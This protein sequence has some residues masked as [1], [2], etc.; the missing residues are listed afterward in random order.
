MAKYAI[1]STT[2]TGIADAIREKAGTTGGIA[3]SQMAESILA[4]KGGLALDVVTAS[5]LPGTVVDGQIVV[6]STTPANHVYITTDEP[7]TAEVGDI[8]IAIEPGA[9]IRW[10]LTDETSFIRGGLAYAAQ[11]NGTTW[12]I[13]EAYYGVAGAWEQFSTTLPPVGTPLESMPWSDIAKIAKAGKGADYF[14][15]GDKK[16]VPVSG[17]VGSDTISGTRYCKIIGINHNKSIEG[18]GIH[19]QFLWNGSD[20]PMAW[21]YGHGTTGQGYMMNSSNS[22][23]GGWQSSY[24]RNT[25]C[26]TFL[27]RL[28]AEMQAAIK[29]CRK[30]TDNTGNANSSDATKVTETKD[31]IFL[32]SEY[33]VF[34]SAGYGNAGEKDYQAQYEYY[35]AG[36]RKNRYRVRST[37]NLCNWWLRSAHRASTNKYVAV[38]TYGSIMVGEAYYS[39]GFAPC[40]MV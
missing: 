4:I 16:S 18:N 38:D 26:A 6:E 39:Y 13:C 17:T 29:E 7:A 34:G 19:F 36:N 35:A 3:T 2:L 23:V 22:N 37:S 31:K 12:V 15:V 10:E 5:A 28:P 14:K 20:N 30:Y 40:F 21:D 1:D 32:L 9:E 11:W 25:L 33:E 8:L 24:M 27:T